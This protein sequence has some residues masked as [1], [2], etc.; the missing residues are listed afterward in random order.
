MSLLI[1]LLAHCVQEGTTAPQVLDTD[2]KTRVL[3]ATSA[4]SALESL[5]NVHQ[6]TTVKELKEKSVRFAQ[7][8]TTVPWA[9]KSPSLVVQRAYVMRAPQVPSNRD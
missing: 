7:P 8:D 4:H 3:V 2:M 6:A 5:L 9:L 1:S